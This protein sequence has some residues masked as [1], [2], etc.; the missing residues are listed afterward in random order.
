MYMISMLALLALQGEI[1]VMS[2]SSPP[3]DEWY[4]TQSARCGENH[5]TVQQRLGRNR[6]PQDRGLFMLNG[7]P[8]TGEAS[9]QLHEDIRTQRSV[10]RYTFQCLD[11]GG[12]FFMVLRAH[13]ANGATTY[14]QGWGQIEQ[15]TLASYTGQ[16]ESSEEAFF[17]R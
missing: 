12:I 1:S 15:G 3:A 14:T 16:H 17:F 10:L 2:G 7:A 9:G 8:L 6:S 13:Y 4:D 5:L 11:S